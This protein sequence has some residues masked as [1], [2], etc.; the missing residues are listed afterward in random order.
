MRRAG[1]VTD[2][3]FSGVTFCLVLFGVRVFGV[4]G[5]RRATLIFLWCLLVAIPFRVA[6]IW[7][8]QIMRPADHA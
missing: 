8:R 5:Y 1:L 7:V 2:W 4:E 3:F 6:G